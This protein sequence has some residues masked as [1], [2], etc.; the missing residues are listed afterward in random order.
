MPRSSFIVRRAVL[1]GLACLALAAFTAARAETQQWSTGQVAIAFDPSTFSFLADT[2]YSGPQEVAASY[3]QVGQG[4]LLNFGGLLNAFA[5]SY[6]Y[7]SPD[8]RAGQFAA[9]FDF[10]PEAGYAITGYTVTYTGGYFVE[11]PASVGLSGQGGAILL[12]GHVGGDNFSLSSYHGGAA[13]PQ[14]AGDLGAWAGVDYIE[15]LDHYEQVFSHYEQ[16]L[17]YC[18]PD[19]PTIC[20]YNEVPVYREEPVYRYESDL[21]EAQIYL[22]TINVQAHV[23]AVPEPGAVAMALAGLASAGSWGARRRR[24]TRIA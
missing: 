16:V 11:S 24:A 20:H 1:P 18:E 19:D 14:I 8:S 5:S 21:G 13:A 12:N 17:D 2:I 6:N 10:T 22:N 9:F 23:T 7:F 15:V 3:A 4:V